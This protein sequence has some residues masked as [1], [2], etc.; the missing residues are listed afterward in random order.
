MAVS[1]C[2]HR[3]AVELFRLWKSEEEMDL[4]GTKIPWLQDFHQRKPLE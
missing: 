2:L 1:E 3:E 4:S